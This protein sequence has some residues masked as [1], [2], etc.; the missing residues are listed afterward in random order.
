M[1]WGTLEP[2]SPG[3]NLAPSAP[4]VPWRFERL[5]RTVSS[6]VADRDVTQGAVSRRGLGWESQGQEEPV[7]SASHPDSFL[8]FTSLR[9]LFLHDFWH[10]HPS[11]LSPSSLFSVSS[12]GKAALSEGY[13]IFWIFGPKIVRKGREENYRSQ[14]T[15]SV[16]GTMLRLTSSC[17]NP[18]TYR[19][20]NRFEEASCQG[21]RASTL[22]F[23]PRGP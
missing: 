13:L 12:V 18:S 19:R 5:K 8:N 7:I 21:H 17:L 1:F 14:N 15:Y 9:S 6:A 20:E 3:G 11:I 10:F 16:P 23:A 2:W 22:G 4:L